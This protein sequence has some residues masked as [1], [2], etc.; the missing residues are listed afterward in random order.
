MKSTKIYYCLRGVVEVI[1]SQQCVGGEKKNKL[2]HS[3]KG[4]GNLF[5]KAFGSLETP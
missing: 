5:A 3:E 4:L 2:L 1:E